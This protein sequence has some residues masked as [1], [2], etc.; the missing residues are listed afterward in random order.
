RGGGRLTA[1]VVLASVV[2]FASVVVGAAAV[3]AGAEAAVVVETA[4][5]SPF[6][7]ASFGSL[8]K[9][10]TAAIIEQKK[11]THSATKPPT[12]VL[13][14]KSRRKRGSRNDELSAKATK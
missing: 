4:G 13:P 1:V 2:V 9:N 14:G 11:S 5:V 12:P 3:V 8:P 10:H 6:A 7:V